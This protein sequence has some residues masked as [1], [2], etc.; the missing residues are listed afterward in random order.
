[1]AGKLQFEQLLESRAV[2][3]VMFDVTWCGGLTEARKIA[4]MAD[5]FELP[6]APHTAGGPLLFYATTHLST[7]SPN[8]WIQESC[9]RFYERD[10]PAMLENPIAPRGRIHRRARGKRL[11]NADQAGSLESPRGRPAGERRLKA[12]LAAQ[13]LSC[14]ARKE[15]AMKLSRN[16]AIIALGIVAT[17][18]VWGQTME[19]AA[20][21][22]PLYRV[23]VIAR[24]VD[25]V[26]Y[27]YRS[28]PT[29]IDFRGTVLLPEAK[30][31]ATVESK[32]GRTEIDARFDRILPP[33]R[34][35]PEYLTY[36]LWAITPE[37]HAK[38]LGE[39]LAG[40]SDKAKTRVTTD[41]QAFG[42]IVT[43]EPYAA[44]REPS[45]V[46]VME[47]QIR[48]DTV[49]KIEPIRAKYEL[50][51]RGRYTYNVPADL[52]AA[53]GN[54]PRVPMSQYEEIVEVYQAQNAV[55][56]AA[57]MGADR[58]AADTLAHAQQLLQDA[59]N[60]QAS[61]ADKSQVIA[62]AREAAQTAEDAR[63]IA[64]KR[65]D[66]EGVAAAKAEAAGERGRR[67][68]AEAA[69]QAAQAQSSAD[70]A[71]LDQ[72]RNALNRAEAQAA[73]A[74]APTPAPPVAQVVIQESPARVAA[75][76]KRDLRMSLYQRLGA[77]SLETM[78]TPRGLVATI[79]ARE[80]DGNML[81]AAAGNL[82]AQ[83]AAVIAAHPGLRVE[84]DEN[85]EGGN[86]Q[87]AQAVR[88]ALVV[89]ERRAGG[90]IAVQSAGSSGPSPPLP[91]RK[92]GAEPASARS[93]FPAIRSVICL[94]FGIA[95][96]RLRRVN[97]GSAS[98]ASAL[99]RF[100]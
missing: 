92:A 77:S 17:V 21:N 98:S 89:A 4:G 35:G 69:A 63:I 99:G 100:L 66:D 7:A 27:Q 82:L 39:V 38:N 91:R 9:Q 31:G 32:A 76:R 65:K 71:A 29:Q 54:G 11:R 8:V 53:E 34:Y 59:R 78:D 72:Q 30:G 87:R 85:G 22:V 24:T 60:L 12:R 5:A 36:V 42:L 41:L 14:T 18:T 48:P 61:H 19:P 57:A 50:L 20:Q 93:S 16:P 64:Q 55:Q 2:K 33:T 80:F 83:A 56:I 95:A 10:W 73:A 13:V 47:N 96:I 75:L 58:Y 40:S 37:G 68:Q 43:A 3:Y 51:P 15:M 28:G 44:V 23:T 62:S 52:V 90:C 6:I 67:L 79:P 25:A 46:V 94:V 88:A 1:M 26:N 74:A 81:R 45:D 84:V 70:R 97:L 86:T 49:G